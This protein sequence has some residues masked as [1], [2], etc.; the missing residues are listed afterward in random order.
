MFVL[1]PGS[2]S[3]RIVPTLAAWKHYGVARNVY[4]V[5]LLEKFLDA[6]LKLLQIKI[7]AFLKSVVHE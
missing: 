6:I 2:T 5:F 4:F 1:R 3:L 7:V